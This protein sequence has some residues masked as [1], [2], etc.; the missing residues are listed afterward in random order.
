MAPDRVQTTVGSE[1]VGLTAT[2]GHSVS[3]AKRED[4]S[5]K[6]KI[7]GEEEEEEITI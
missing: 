2:A 6:C 1:P 5:G 3:A 4:R 7:F